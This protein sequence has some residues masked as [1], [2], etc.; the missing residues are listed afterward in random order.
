MITITK[1]RGLRMCN[2]C[3]HIDCTNRTEYGYC[4]TTACINPKYN[5]IQIVSDKTLTDEELNEY[6][7]KYNSY[8]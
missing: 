4:K 8:Q 5:Q 6:I 7:K 1:K 2:V 3:M